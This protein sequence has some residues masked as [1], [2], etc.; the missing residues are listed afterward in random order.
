MTITNEKYQRKE[1]C[2]AYVAVKIS[3]SMNMKR[4]NEED[5]INEKGVKKKL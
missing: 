2:E 4:N 1:K 5:N 3:V